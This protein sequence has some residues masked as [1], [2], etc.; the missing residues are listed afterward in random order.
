MAVLGTPGTDLYDWAGAE[1]DEGDSSVEGARPGYRQVAETLRTRIAD[2]TYPPRTAIPGQQLLSD[3]LGADIAVVNRAVDLLE[4][5][6]LVQRAGRG[7][8]TM[9]V[10]QGQ[11]RVELVV[12][13]QPALADPDAVFSAFEDAVRAAV[14]ADPASGD[15]RVWPVGHGR[16]LMAVKLVA[17][18]TAP[19]P[20]FAA[21]RLTE[22]VRAA[23]PAHYWNVARS[24]VS[25]APE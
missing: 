10:E 23:A 9:V 8:K 21:N 2:G 6:G 19:H 7:R 25:A 13:A 17:L 1:T 18:V 16:G 5:E 24:V 22:L 20:G 15:L 3:Q 11:F 4:A 12:D 14:G